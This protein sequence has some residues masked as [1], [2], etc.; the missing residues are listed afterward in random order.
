V[1][2][3]GLDQVNISVSVSCEETADSGQLR[4]ILLKN[5]TEIFAT[6]G[7]GPSGTLNFKFSKLAEGDRLSIS[8]RALTGTRRIKAGDGT[9]FMI[10]ASRF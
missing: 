4:L 10:Q 5:G 6:A 7:T 8:A 3:G 2:Q 1:P 9:V